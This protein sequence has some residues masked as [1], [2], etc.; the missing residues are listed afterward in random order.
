ME[1]SEDNIVIK[2]NDIEFRK[3][4]IE[5][6]ICYVKKLQDAYAQAELECQQWKKLY[7]GK[8]EEK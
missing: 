3:K 4:D 2:V 8:L 5:E 6:L 1:K 7:L